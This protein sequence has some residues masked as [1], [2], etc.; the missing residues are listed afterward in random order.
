MARDAE[1]TGAADAAGVRREAAA[2]R[3][4][5]LAVVAGPQFG[6]LLDLEIGAE[7][8]LGR[9]ADS[10][11]SLSGDFVLHD[12]LCLYD[13]G[14]SRR[15]AAL[16]AR[17]G[18]ATLRDLESQNGTWVEGERIGEVLLRDGQQFSLGAHT[19]LRFVGC[20][21][22]DA[23]LLRA[24]AQ[25]ALREPLTGLHNRRHVLERLTAELAASQRHG[26]PL[27]LLLVDLDHAKR[28]NEAHGNP[29]GDEA[30]RVVG[31]VLQGTVRK[32]DE[33]A[34]FGGGAFA[35]LARE[36]GLSGARVLAER[37]R[38]AVQKA[39]VPWGGRDFGVTVSVGAAVSQGLTAFE[40]GRTERQLLEAADRTLG[41]AKQMGRNT[42]VA[43][44]AA[45]A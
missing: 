17:A 44:P 10:G 42:V 13:S 27:S 5:F 22:P 8:I 32:E 35:V 19:T 18:D 15:H 2:V 34:R 23:A 24:L 25:G 43:A 36:T 33:L 9:R 6:D 12:D 16:V 28:I 31:R 41:R 45:G 40:P 11:L 38:K 7:V 26:R 4:P 14:V 21:H 30:I 3:R 20:D 1:V 29:G 37:I 39:H